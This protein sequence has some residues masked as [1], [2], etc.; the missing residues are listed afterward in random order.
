MYSINIPLGAH[1]AQI[2]SLRHAYAATLHNGNANVKKHEI[3]KVQRA[4]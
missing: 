1:L 2:T 3:W 4:D